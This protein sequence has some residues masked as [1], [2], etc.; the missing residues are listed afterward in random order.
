MART[1][2]TSTPT[3]PT[4]SP[5]EA[6]VL[7][8]AE[9]T[10]F[11]D[12]AIVS[13]ALRVRHKEVRELK[14]QRERSEA[15]EYVSR[16]KPGTRLFLHTRGRT[17][18]ALLQRGDA[19]KIEHVDLDRERIVVRPCEVAGKRTSKFQAQYW[20]LREI[21][22]HAPKR[23]RPSDPVSAK[24]RSTDREVLATINRALGDE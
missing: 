10:E 19:V 15:W 17:I 24:A 6:I 16:C 23:E 22:W 18:G 8:I 2:T 12:L 14:E 5:T 1:R 21:A 9:L 4:V 20:D 3:E 7:A 13:E 11:S